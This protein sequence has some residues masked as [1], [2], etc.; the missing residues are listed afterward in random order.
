MTPPIEVPWPPMYFVA[1][2]TTMSAPRSNG[3]HRK[4]VGAVLSTISGRPCSCAASAQ[5]RM[6][7]TLIFGLP[8][9]SAKTSLVLS[10]TNF[11]RSSGL[12]G[13]TKRTSMPNWGSVCANSA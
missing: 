5:A 6:S 8:M 12:F 2:C 3:L 11:A 4:G 13:S 10:S 7:T 1:E 9:V